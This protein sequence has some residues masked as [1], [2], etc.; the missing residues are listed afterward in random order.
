MIINVKIPFAYLFSTMVQALSHIS[1]FI[2]V[3]ISYLTI[4][5]EGKIVFFS[6]RHVHIKNNLGVGINLQ[7]HCKSKDD[8]L[9]VHN[10]TYG[11]DYQF[12]FRPNVFGT[13][14]F[15]CGLAWNGILHYLDAYIH[16]RDMQRC[17]PDCFWTI[18]TNQACLYNFDHPSQDCTLI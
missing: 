7:V 4:L 10:V 12:Q 1:I 6:V 16:Q 17:D 8:D 14:Q 5:N 2:L 3:L 13:T 18:Y 11:G 15:F 9:G